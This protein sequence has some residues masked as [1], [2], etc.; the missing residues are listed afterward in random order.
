MTNIPPPTYTALDTDNE[1]AYGTHLQRLAKAANILT[2]FL[3]LRDLPK[4]RRSVLQAKYG[5]DRVDVMIL[6]G[7]TIPFG[8]EVAAAAWKRGLARQ[9]MVVGGIGHTT[10]FLRNKFKARYPQMETLGKTEAEM[11]ADYLSREHGI[12]DLLLETKST[13]CGNN[14]TYALAM[15]RDSGIAAKAILIMQEPSMQRRMAAVFHKELSDDSGTLI[16]N[17]APYLPHLTAANGRL[18]FLRQY[19]GLWDIEHY[20]TLLLGDVSRLRDDENGYGPKGKGFI[21]HVDIPLEVEKA[22]TLLASNH[23]G[24]IRTPNPAFKS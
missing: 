22:F 1:Q 14:V 15:L 4:L 13:N 6:F 19:W 2:S 5:I 12:H 9:L 23:I 17:Y 20:I 8:C 11:I 10:Q 7:G 21:P 18:S 3:G 16:I 24:T